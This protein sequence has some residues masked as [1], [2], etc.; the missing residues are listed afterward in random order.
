M[1]YRQDLCRISVYLQRELTM[2]TPYVL[3]VLDGWGHRKGGQDNAIALGN[4]P[5]W[6]NLWQHQPHSLISASGFDVGLPDGQMG[7]SEV[8]HMNLGTG[9]VV[10]QDFTRINKSIEDGS[11]NKNET[12]LDLTAQLQQS[13][14]SLHILGL[15]SPGGVH[16]HELQIKAAIDLAFDRGVSNVY[17]HAFLDG[18]DVP[19]SSAASSLA[20]A[21]RWFEGSGTGGI[22]TIMGRFYAMDRDQRWDRTEKAYG[23]ITE[24]QAPFHEADTQ[25]A[26][27][28]AYARG[29][30][31][32]FVQPT[33]VEVN[34]DSVPIADGDTVLFMNF[35]AD[36]ARQLTRSFINDEF[37]DFDRGSIPRLS[38]FVTLTQ[39]A[40]DIQTKIAFGPASLRNGLGEY[41]SDLGKTQ[42]RLAE[43]EKYAHVTFFFSGGIEVPFPLEDRI[44][45][46]SPKV[47]TYDLQ[48][49]MSALEVTKELEGAILSE[50]YDL[51]VCNYANGDMVGHTGDLDAAVEA[52]ECI[53]GCLARI[54]DAVQQVSGHC[55][56]TADHGNVEQ[57]NDAKTGQAHTAH[58]NELVPLVYVGNKDLVLTT[59]TLRDVAPTLLDLMDLPRPSEM[60]GESL[61]EATA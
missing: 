32:E 30:T 33:T 8:G 19:P 1:N 6:D 31:D 49:T 4:T 9:R 18:R 22:A 24:A 26:L 58:T 48:P 51:V 52:V 46:P 21:E 59:G 38:Q 53:D 14:K 27:Q 55:L 39:Y 2:T 23:A 61:I 3:I 60:T 42:L 13:G 7:N 50:K 35:R 28:A 41:L 57:M 54:I 40:E 34:G 12:L 15:L 25:T 44:L 29:E 20:A 11:F 43:T 10:D 36:R 5:T 17:L 37:N 47:E 56:I 16:S 45:I